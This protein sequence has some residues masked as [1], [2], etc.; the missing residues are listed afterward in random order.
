MPIPPLPEIYARLEAA[1]AWIVFH[2]PLPV[3][4]LPDPE[5]LA[6]VRLSMRLV[7]RVILAEG[8]LSRTDAQLILTSLDA[9]VAYLDSVTGE[10][11][12]IPPAAPATL[13]SAALRRLL[14]S[15]RLKET[16]LVEAEL[17]D[18]PLAKDVVILR[19]SRVEIEPY[20]ATLRES[21]V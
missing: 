1:E 2:T 21:V 16:F 11:P 18:G 12:E 17:R 6:D 20:L 7:E 14:A 13:D 15:F 8:G 5:I 10:S 19:A 9:A 3:P 4:Y